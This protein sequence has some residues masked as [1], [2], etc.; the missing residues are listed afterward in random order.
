LFWKIFEAVIRLI[1]F[2]RFRAAKKIGEAGQLLTDGNPQIALHLLEKTG[3]SVHQSLLPIYA[4]TRGKILDALHREDEAQEA[5]KLVVLADPENARADLE[6]AILSGKGFR[7]D[8]CREWLDRLE[9]KDDAEAKEQGKGVGTLL[10]QVTSGERGR[11]FEERAFQMAKKEIGE[12][13]AT[14]GFPPNLKILDSW[15]SR[16]P[17]A[18]RVLFDEIALLVGQSEVAGGGSWKVS[19]SIDRSVIVYEHGNEI[20]PFEIV[21][22]RFESDDLSLSELIEKAK[23]VSRV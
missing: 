15:I 1:Y 7:F 14:P 5:F 18:A 8:E 17:K 3:R 2:R 23:T 21:A 12:N 19:L 4:F 6:L 20:S 11:E 16:D 13:G 9:E 10:A 22:D